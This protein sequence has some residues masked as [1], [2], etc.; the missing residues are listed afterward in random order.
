MSENQTF[1]DYL[2]NIQAQPE[3][4]ASACVAYVEEKTDGQSSSAMYS[5]LLQNAKDADAVDRML[6]QLE[7]DPAYAEQS[8]LIVLG[9][10]WN[11]PEARDAIRALAENSSGDAA[12]ED[13]NARA[14]TVLYGMYL[15]AR[16]NVTLRE[17]TY[18]NAD[19]SLESVTVGAEITP[20]RL[21]DDV[22]DLYGAG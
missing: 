6:Y 18:R 12:D 17:V 5:D 10:A 1:A 13:A 22:R 9:A 20:A 7:G 3:A 8:A 14:V 19:G 15:L 2:T 4:I 11:Q 21:F 16:D